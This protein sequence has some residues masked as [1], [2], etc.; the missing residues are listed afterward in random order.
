M[1]AGTLTTT[2][3]ASKLAPFPLQ[4]G[5]YSSTTCPLPLQLGQV[6]TLLNTPKGVLCMLFTTPLPLQLTQVLTFA[7]GLMPLPEQVLHSSSLRTRTFSWPPKT[8]VINGISTST[9]KSS[10]ATGALGFLGWRIRPP[11]IPPPPKNDSNISEIS[12]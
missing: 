6:T 5:Q 2:S 9:C 12:P 7:P 11:P 3:C 4:V 8:D 10:P 1:P